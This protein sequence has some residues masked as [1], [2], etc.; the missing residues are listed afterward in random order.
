MRETNR[1]RLR[2]MA[3]KLTRER[4]EMVLLTELRAEACEERDVES[5]MSGRFVV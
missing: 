5:D 3:E 2:R 4:W 1:R